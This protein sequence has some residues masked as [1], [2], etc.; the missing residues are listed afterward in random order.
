MHA[1]P[2]CREPCTCDAGQPGSDVW[3]EPPVDC[4]H[5]CEVL[6]DRRERDDDDPT[7]D[8]G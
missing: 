4:Q 6:F 2:I 7:E 8:A 3:T 1:C 5:E